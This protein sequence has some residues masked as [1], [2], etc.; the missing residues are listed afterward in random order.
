MSARSPRPSSR[1]KRKRPGRFVSAGRAH[2]AWS[3][4]VAT[5]RTSY[6]DCWCRP[7]SGDARM[8]RTRSW[9]IDGSKPAANNRSDSSGGPSGRNARSCT[10]PREVSSSRPSPRSAAA[11]R[12]TSSCALVSRPPG[13]RTRARPPSAASC[14]ASTPGHRSVSVLATRAMLRAR[15]LVCSGPQQRADR[16][17][18]TNPAGH[19]R[20]RH[21]PGVDHQPTQQRAGRQHRLERRREPDRRCLPRLRCSAREHAHRTDRYAAVPEP[22]HDEQRERTRRTATQHRHEESRCRDQSRAGG[23]RRGQVARGRRTGDEVADQT[24]RAVDEQEYANELWTYDVAQERRH[25]GVGREMRG[26]DQTGDGERTTAAAE[27]VAQ[28]GGAGDLH[29]RERRH[30]RAE[31]GQCDKRQYAERDERRSPAGDLTDERARWYAEDR[32]EWYGGEDHG[33]CPRRPALRDQ[34]AGE[35]GTDR[36]E[37]TD[38]Q[39]DE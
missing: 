6:F 31:G 15:G 5:G 28:Y 36:P 12:S 19:H 30:C 27:S 39:A 2:R 16:Q 32:T 23:E 9:V 1:A 13:S 4:A 18:R 17:R 14:T 29:R 11:I 37:T 3:S 21:R 38:G 34:T 33:G 24:C 8:L 22:P 20:R 35:T 10:F 25:I 26:D 7:E